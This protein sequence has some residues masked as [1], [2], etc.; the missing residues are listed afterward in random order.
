M[1]EI[2][3]A[4]LDIIEILRKWKLVFKVDYGDKAYKVTIVQ[5]GNYIT[6]K[7][8]MDIIDVLHKRNVYV[9]IIG[10]EEG[11]ELYIVK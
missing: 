7:Q 10:V 9:G 3:D 1:N 6:S 11:I 8:M 4:V 2:W 5:S